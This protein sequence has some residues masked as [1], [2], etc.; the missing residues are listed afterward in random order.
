MKPR[1]IK[2]LT[3]KGY[4]QYATS[5]PGQQ[6]RIL[7]DHKYPAEKEPGAKSRYYKASLDLIVRY[8]REAHPLAWLETQAERLHNE[9]EHQKNNWRAGKLRRNAEVLRA[10]AR[11]FGERRFEVLGP[12]KLSLHYRDVRISAVPDL[13]VREHDIEKIIKFEF[14]VNAPPDEIVKIVTQG[15][16]EA[17]HKVGFDFAGKDVLVVDVLRGKVHRG[18]RLG[19]RRGAEIEAACLTISAVWDTL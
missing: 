4:A 1:T 2:Q 15:L 10:Y 7:W 3:I 8:H 14:G 9:A 18:A 17:A 12:L 13:H 11:H 5:S 19:A 16:F 6:R